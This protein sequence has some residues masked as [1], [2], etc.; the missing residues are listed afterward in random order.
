[1][2]MEVLISLLGKDFFTLLPWNEANGKN[3]TL[4]A[5]FWYCKEFL[6]RVSL[7]TLMTAFA[8]LK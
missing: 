8:H 4:E 2:A 1:M 6:C 5:M 3:L 7:P